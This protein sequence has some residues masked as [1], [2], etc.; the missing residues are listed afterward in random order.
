MKIKSRK[1]YK[2][3]FRIF[4]GVGFN[5]FE[6]KDYWQ[7]GPM[8]AKYDG[9]VYKVYSEDD[10][11]NHFKESLTA[12]HMAMYIPPSYWIGVAEEVHNESVFIDNLIQK[13][14]RKEEFELLGTVCNISKYYGNSPE[15][16]WNALHQVSDI[17]LYPKAI[18]SAAATYDLDSM[19]HELMECML[20]DGENT[21]SETEVGIFETICLH[22][23]TNKE[24]NYYIYT[25]DS[26]S[27]DVE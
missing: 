2:E 12:F 1:N 21:F 5:R 19:I 24:T 17:E 15:V 20:T 9:D 13:L 18:V 16:F 27:W 6:I 23:H 10:M 7:D 8:I 4:S 25:A 26:C 22:E 14:D 11:F 3:V